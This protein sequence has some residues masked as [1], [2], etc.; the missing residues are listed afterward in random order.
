[1]AEPNA[2]GRIEVNASPQRVYELLS[3]LGV[4]AE[5]AEEYSGHRWLDGADKAVVGA[6]FKGSNRRGFRRWSTT[7]EITDAWAGRRFA[8]EVTSVAGLPVSRWQYDITATE[9]GCVVTESTWERRPGWLKLPTSAVTGVF[10]RDEQN[11]RNIEA[12]LRR[13]KT[14]AEASH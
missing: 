7:S 8:F 11:Q 4:L 1:M 3:D 6:R 13:L 10:Q 5:L 9:T 14:R 12:T 2:K